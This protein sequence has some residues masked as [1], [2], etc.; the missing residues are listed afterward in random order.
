MKLA[1]LVRSLELGGTERQL[2]TLTKGLRQRGHRVSVLVFYSGGALAP[3]LAEAGASV[4]HLG[5][6]GR[7]DIVGFL[8]RTYRAVRREEADILY[9]FLPTANIVAALIGVLAPDLRFVWGL[10]AAAVDLAS[11]DWLAGLSYRL[12]RALARLPRLIIVNSH[13]AY[14]HHVELGYPADKMVVIPNGID[15]HRFA[16]D[17]EAGR[18]LRLKWGIGPDE[19]LIGL[20]ARIDPMKDHTTFLRA[21]AIA[22]NDGRDLR[23]VCI[24][25]GPA[26]H[27][28]RVLALAEDLNL[29]GRVIW[30]GACDDM[31]PAY[32][33]FD[34]A[35]NSSCFGE[36]FSN[37]IG[38]AMACG[39]PC[40]VTDVGDSAL[41]VGDTGL[42]VAPRDPAA[43][44]D[45]WRR[46]LELPDEARADMGLRARQRICER[47]SVEALSENV[48][49]TL[50]ELM[51]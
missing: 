39:V 34:I 3:A 16:P 18:R 23:A 45:G 11:Y 43:L 2:V 41:I 4:I 17:I 7:W 19:R 49:R 13:A 28:R 15:S 40:V 51:R 1:C 14:D 10:R 20:A 24:G 44:A 31:P 46:L 8:W 5:K 30:A 26:D 9:S 47:F 29:K 33:A 35:T 25:D 37:A 22:L 48:D 12:E 36:S 6:A 21:V 50:R 32:N 27:R 38:E 42:T